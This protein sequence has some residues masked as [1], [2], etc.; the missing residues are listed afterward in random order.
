[1]ILTAQNIRA[2]STPEGQI[3]FALPAAFKITAEAPMG[4]Q[5]G[6]DTNQ[7]GDSP[8]PNNG[9][10][11][12]KSG[13]PP[14][15]KF[16][17]SIYSGGTMRVGGYKLPV[18]INCRGVRCAA[19]R[20]PVYAN[21][22][23][24]DTSGSEMIEQLIGQTGGPCTV[25]Q[26]CT[27]MASGEVTGQSET[28]KSVMAHAANGFQWQASI[29]AMPVRG[30]VIAEGDSEEING[31]MIAGPVFVADESVLANVAVV[32]LGADTTTSAN[33]AAANPARS[34]DMEFAAWLKAEYEMTVAEYEALAKDKPGQHGK[35]KA[36]WDSVGKIAAG[37]T[38]GTDPT[39]RTPAASGGIV[40]SAAG[41]AADP[42]P[43]AD[44]IKASRQARASEARRVAKLDQIQAQYAKVDVVID[45]KPVK[46][47]DYIANCIEAGTEPDAAELVLLRA[48]RKPTES[49]TAPAAII[50]GS[51]PADGLQ[52]R[53]TPTERGG[54]QVVASGGR[55]SNDHAAV[56]EACGLIS[57]GYSADR[58]A[59]NPAYGQRVVEM[60]DAT[61]RRFGRGL[62][63]MGLMRLA[64]SFA[65]VQLPHSNDDAYKSV[66]AEFSTL[67]LPTIL[68]NLMN[69]FLIDS[70][71]AVDPD[72]FVDK[73]AKEGEKQTT[74]W[75]KITK[76]G[77]VQ[78]FKPHYRV[79]IVSDMT[80]RDLGPTG[81]IQHGK[82][83][84][85]SYKI[86][87]ITKAIMFALTRQNIV[88]DDLSAMSSLPTH[89]GRGAGITIAK[90]V[91]GL[92]IAALQSDRA[93]AF[94][95]SGAITTPGNLMQPNLL[96][97]AGLSLATLEAAESA[98]M[99]QTDPYGLP[100][101][102]IPEV[103]VVPPGLLNLARQL[104]QSVDLIASLS[105]GGNGRG[106][107]QRNTLAGRF[108]PVCSQYMASL[109]AAQINDAI[110][111][112]G[113]TNAGSNSTWYLGAG[114]G[115][116]AYP[117]EVG[118]L[119]GQEMPIVE[120]DE[121]DFDRL[122]IAFRGWIDFGAN[123]AEPRSIVKNIA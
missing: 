18:A 93:T 103:L 7:V 20:F 25:M 64:A 34:S 51:F 1:M 3:R 99:S 49:G 94:F 117:L 62:G 123:L 107:P 61:M 2:A 45:G 46:A 88:D 36:K 116:V 27:L 76:R 89:F 56:V 106:S 110:T 59:A 44:Q 63:P 74:A 21:H 4:N 86:Q 90:F 113:T 26:G 102:L 23:D 82:A 40:A 105:T 39:I 108:R 79:R 30:H 84:E 60:A 28:V 115:Q 104:Y 73:D 11:A 43:D 96:T 48:S 78:D 16:S 13:K 15:P 97:G 50:G 75:Q 12:G 121:M 87:A 54:R 37:A 65:G 8:D 91:W 10:P 14:L 17:L 29:D 120:R 81:E 119:N 6:L 57:A 66:L 112:L 58:L 53:A 100:A 83:S 118:F 98:F 77:P 80:M 85:Q 72:W 32:P 95:T 9:K 71:M 122:G 67:S 52:M 19:D 47:A 24:A 5:A 33:F 31:K 109:T 68:S 41:G 69:K 114:P 55:F 92:L 111:G 35:I 70:W 42:N 22:I 101:G 38:T